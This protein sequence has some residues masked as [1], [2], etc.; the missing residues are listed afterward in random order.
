MQLI[1]RAQIKKLWLHK[2]PKGESPPTGRDSPFFMHV[3]KE[4]RE[5]SIQQNEIKIL[6]QLLLVDLSGIHL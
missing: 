6:D 2:N 3:R 1:K 4:N 5:M